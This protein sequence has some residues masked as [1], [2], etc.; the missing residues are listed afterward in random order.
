LRDGFVVDASTTRAPAGFVPGGFGVASPRGPVRE[1]AAAPESFR[2][3]VT[4]F[5][6]QRFTPD[7]TALTPPARVP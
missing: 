3:K 5:A 6:S 7:H 2:F 1:G 4:A